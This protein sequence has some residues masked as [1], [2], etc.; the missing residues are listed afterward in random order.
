VILLPI[1]PQPKEGEILSSWMVRLSLSNHFQLHTFYS[2]LLG[3]TQPI[4]TR[5][6]DRNPAQTLLD[7]L[8]TRSGCS[9]SQLESLCLRSYEGLL[10]E[11][12]RLNGVAKW[13]LP[14]G[15]FH[16]TRIRKGIQ[17]CPQCLREGIPF[18]CMKW[19]ISLFTMC[20]I[21]KCFLIDACPQCHA[22]I[23]YHR[24]GINKGDFL[25][26]TPLSDCHNCGFGLAKAVPVQPSHL[27]ERIVSD[28][29]K[30]LRMIAKNRWDS[31]LK[32]PAFY[33]VAFFDGLKAILT[34]LNKRSA[35]ALRKKLNSQFPVD[36]PLECPGAIEFG[37][38][39]VTQ[40]FKLVA[41]ALWLLHD[42][43]FR[44][45]NLLREAGQSRSR[46]A[47]DPNALPF[48]LL[49]PL[50]DYLDLR[51]YVPTPDEIESVKTYLLAKQGIANTKAM[52]DLLGVGVDCTRT[53]VANHRLY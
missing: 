17:C 35:A 3:Y 47:E 15:V 6:V 12:V 40:R 37:Y 11:D 32:L 52:A 8:S 1:H 39:D 42:W 16:R 50:N 38:L 43:P 53:L 49:R 45:V 18:F 4:W 21:H 23:E 48:W 20:E 5:D 7:I 24:L 9:V 46:F 33:P 44:L 22:N 30:L 51:I 36:L 19:R 27:P 10:Y 14:I 31:S 28:Y 25:S 2:K 29:Q 13:V 34:L 41:A 26:D